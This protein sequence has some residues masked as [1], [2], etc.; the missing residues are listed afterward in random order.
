M[1]CG[2][3]GSDRV[4]WSGDHDFSDHGLDG[5]GIVSNYQCPDCNTSIVL[6]VPHDKV[7]RKQVSITNGEL[8]VLEDWEEENDR[9]YK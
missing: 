2:N 7:V 8:E 6:Y 3:C 9:S 1:I 5:N 4:Y